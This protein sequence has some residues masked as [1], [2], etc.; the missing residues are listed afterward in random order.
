[1]NA[2]NVVTRARRPETLVEL[3]AQSAIANPRRPAVSDDSGRQLSY[4][5]LD[6]LSNGLAERLTRDG[7]RSEDRIGVSRPRDCDFLVS[8]LG[9]LR[10]GATYV[11]VDERYPDVRRDLMLDAAGVRLTLIAPSADPSR[12]GSRLTLAWSSQ[13]DASAVDDVSTV[14]AAT[15]ALPG[16]TDAAC[17][18]FTS[19]STGTPKGVVLEH[20]NV[21]AFATNGALAPLAS[22][23]RVA[24]ISN[25]SFDAAHFEIW[26]SLFANAELVIMPSL[27]DLV[28]ADLR[29]ELRRR[30][31]TVMLA[32]T[33][34]VNHVA[35][36]DPKA[37]SGLRILHTGGDVLRPSACRNLLASGFQGRMFNLYGPTEATTAV[38]SHEIATTPAGESVPIGSPLEGSTVYVLDDRLQPVETGGVGDLYIGGVGVARGYLHDPS[39]TAEHFLPD[40]FAGAGATMYATGDRG[41]DRGD[42]VF[43]YRGR[44]DDQVKIRGYRVEPRAVETAILQH[45]EVRDVA[46]LAPEAG[47]D[48]RLVAF[49]VAQDGLTPHALRS[50]VEASLPDHEV[51]AELVFVSAIPATTHGKRD[52]A[53]L[54][55][56]RSDR[57]RGRDPFAAPTTES[58]RYLARLWEE[59][60]GIERVGIADD[61]YRLGGHSMLAFRVGKRVERELH[62]KLAPIEVL[63]H[64]V[65]ADLATALDAVRARTSV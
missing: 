47:S 28:R 57:E 46:V 13:G 44:A 37:F 45:S 59:L 17:V 29:R 8:I 31:I 1:M 52:T 20:R 61:F 32:P 41:R 36:E 4:A 56:Q 62:L 7:V 9:I 15:S 40:P 50:F 2:S 30:R 43:E 3:F 6:R 33:M 25:V 65:L 12:L 58:E 38:T 11:A 18:L 63:T 55:A 51:P 10:S 49:V 23:D 5:E 22:T 60:L 26:C 34:A 48:R 16:P 54:L 39:R 19:G 21:V 64:T 42:G 24:Q 35:G 14:G 53:G 27:P